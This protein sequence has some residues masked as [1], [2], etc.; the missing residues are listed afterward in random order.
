MQNNFSFPGSRED[1]LKIS[2]YLIEDV[3]D[4]LFAVNFETKTNA[5]LIEMGI[6]I[7]EPEFIRT[8]DDKLPF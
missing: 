5:E 2:K 4:D 7:S 3:F 6:E 8:D 1:W